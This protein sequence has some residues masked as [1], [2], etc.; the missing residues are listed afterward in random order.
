MTI[1]KIGCSL[2]LLILFLSNSLINAETKAV[3]PQ[4]LSAVQNQID[5]EKKYGY[6][7]FALVDVV[8]GTNKVCLIYTAK[9]EMF[10][11][12][13]QFLSA[14]TVSKGSSGDW[15]YV[16]SKTVSHSSDKDLETIKSWAAD[17]VE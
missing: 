6:S 15:I 12:D 17:S 4:I 14:Y 2:I 9:N 3:D 5:K 16:G 7:D 1:K 10:E 13:S 8:N 11:P